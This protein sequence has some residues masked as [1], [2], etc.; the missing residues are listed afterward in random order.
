MANYWT[1]FSCVL[2]VGSP[3]NR[4]R[5]L[6]EILEATRRAEAAAEGEDPDAFALGFEAGPL[7]PPGAPASGRIWLRAGEDGD[8]EHVVAFA[9]ACGAAF[10]LSGRWGFVWALSCSKPRLDGFGG[11]AHVLD[12]ATGETV[13]W[14]DCEHW[15]SA[16]LAEAA[17]A[18]ARTPAA[19]T[20][21]AAP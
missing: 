16:A 21:A 11:G 5:A 18:A 7:E 3:A 4:A 19:A 6:G 12:L 15:L 2:D 8:P 1:Q 13:G 20:A 9:R 17:E 10:G 14:T